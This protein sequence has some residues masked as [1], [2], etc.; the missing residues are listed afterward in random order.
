M[1]VADPSALNVQPENNLQ[2]EQPPAAL[3]TPQ[4]KQDAVLPFMKSLLNQTAHTPEVEHQI[5]QIN[6]ANLIT[7]QQ[8]NEKITDMDPTGRRATK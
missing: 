8:Y 1:A 5:Q 3:Q 6:S 4:M 7:E 2:A